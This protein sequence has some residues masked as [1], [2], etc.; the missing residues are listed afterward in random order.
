MA[1]FKYVTDWEQDMNDNHEDDDG[2]KIYLH[3]PDLFS[4]EYG[5]FVEKIF[6]NNTTQ[7]ISAHSGNKYI[8]MGRGELIEQEF[9]ESDNLEPGKIYKV[10]F[11][12]QPSTAFYFDNGN[13]TSP[14]VLSVML[15]TKKMKYAFHANQP[16]ESCTA[17]FNDHINEDG[18]TLHLADLQI[19]PSQYPFGIWSEISFEFTAPSD[20]GDYDWIIFETNDINST[21]CDTY[22]LLDDLSFYKKEC[23]PNNC[24][25]TSGNIYPTINQYHTK[26]NPFSISNI[27][28]VSHAKIDIVTIFPQALIY[29][30]DVHAT[31]GIKNP[32]YW[33]GKNSNGYDVA[34][35]DYIALITLENE[36]ETIHPN[37]GVVV[38]NQ[39][40]GSFVYPSNSYDNSGYK[41]PKECC[42]YDIYIDNVTIGGP[43]EKRF[44]ASHAVY[45]ATLTGSTVILTSDADVLF[46]AGSFVELGP[47]FDENSP[48]YT[49]EI[50]PCPGRYSDPEDTENNILFSNYNGELPYTEK[51][52]E[53]IIQTTSDA[54]KYYPTQLKI[55]CFLRFK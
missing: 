45:V 30:I 20:A 17:S 25:Q 52:I 38:N 18:T 40:T 37:H 39:S 1:Q 32:I 21:I 12:I 47:G 44:V 5:H 13:W 55:N 34:S 35:G 6:L 11:F 29:T 28:N 48:E 24:S 19:T 36:C 14:T 50:V 43:S 23:D 33:D 2:N 9:Y 26:S 31:N 15:R 22:L 54:I 49:V 51:V 46:K 16:D 4:A 7:I 8:G 42:L 3:S 27:G 10:K 41:I 53:P